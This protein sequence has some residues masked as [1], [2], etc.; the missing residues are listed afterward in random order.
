M[1][2]LHTSWFLL[3]RTDLDC[4]LMVYLYRWVTNEWGS[5]SFHTLH[6]LKHCTWAIMVLSKLQISTCCT[7][8][9]PPPPLQ[10]KDQPH[11]RR[12]Q[13]EPYIL[14]NRYLT[15]TTNILTY[16]QCACIHIYIPTHTY[17]SDNTVWFQFRISTFSHLPYRTTVYVLNQKN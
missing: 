11:R 6:L 4:P 14:C 17:S 12:D 9:G 1:C 5:Y 10:H 7:T 15:P 8:L 16:I 3:D 13:R 2:H